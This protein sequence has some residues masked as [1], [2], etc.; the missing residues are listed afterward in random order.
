M[1][2][3]H[4]S[5]TKN[6]KVLEPLQADHDRPYIYLTTVDVVSAFYVCNAVERPYYWFPYGFNINGITVYYELYPNAFEEVSQGK[7]G[8]LYIVDVDERD[9]IPFKN[10][11]CAR[12]GTKPIPVKECIEIP[13][14]YDFFMEKVAAGELEISRF[15]SKSEKELQ[16]WYKMIKSYLSEKKMRDIPKCSY[17]MFIQRKFPNVWREYIDEN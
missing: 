14:A 2:L 16:N 12:L 4:G 6:I 8:Y 15:E 11:P 7:K 1:I 9:I 5:N 10:I 17:A 3:Y 13:N